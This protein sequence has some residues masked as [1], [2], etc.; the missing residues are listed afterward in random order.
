MSMID[1]DREAFSRDYGCTPNEWLGWMPRATQ[2]LHWRAL[3]AAGRTLTA[4]APAPDVGSMQIDFPD[5]TSPDTSGRL[6]IAWAVQEPRRIALVVLP[7]LRVSFQFQDV[8]L[9]QR[10]AFMRTFDLHLQRGG[11]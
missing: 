8:P 11:G 2:G 9:P 4:S 10:L 3:D 5:E 1:V 6:S 7:R